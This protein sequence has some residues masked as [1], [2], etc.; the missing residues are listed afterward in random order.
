LLGSLRSVPLSPRISSHADAAL[1]TDKLAQITIMS[2]NP[3][4]NASRTD[5]L[6]AAPLV[7]FRLVGNC[8]SESNLACLNVV[9]CVGT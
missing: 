2:R 7:S 5:S 9:E 1:G 3:N 6:I 8:S 4:T